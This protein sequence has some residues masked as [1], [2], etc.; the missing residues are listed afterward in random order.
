MEEVVSVS[1]R[2]HKESCSNRAAQFLE[3]GGGHLCDEIIENLIQP[4]PQMSTVCRSE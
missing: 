2:S 1:K 4:D 3:C